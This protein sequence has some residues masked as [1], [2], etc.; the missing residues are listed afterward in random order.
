MKK[1][2][3]V[4]IVILVL[5]SAC[6]IEPEET[7]RDKFSFRGHKFGESP[8]QAIETEDTDPIRPPEEFD[9]DFALGFGP[10][11]A[12]GYEEAMFSLDFKNHKLWKMVVMVY[13]IED[14]ESAEVLKEELLSQMEEFGEPDTVQR[15]KNSEAIRIIWFYEGYHIELNVNYNRFVIFFLQD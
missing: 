1:L 4:L 6:S 13:Y 14:V 15:F 7:E 2:L 8:E 11:E 3:I 10:V 12:Y 5:L 9:D